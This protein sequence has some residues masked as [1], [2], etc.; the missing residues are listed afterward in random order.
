[1]LELKIQFLHFEY[2]NNQ[3]N[4]V[5]KLQDLKYQYNNSHQYM[6]DTKKHQGLQVAS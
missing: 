4:M 3:Q 5:L 6:V 1:M 2:S